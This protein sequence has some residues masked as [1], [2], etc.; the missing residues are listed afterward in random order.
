MRRVFAATL[1][2]LVVPATAG[3][4]VYRWTDAEGRVHY[5]DRAPD[6]AAQRVDLPPSPPAP[7]D[8]EL[9]EQRER[10]RRLLEVWDAE[11]RERAQAAASAAAATAERERACAWLREELDGARRAAYLV[12]RDAQGGRAIVA[13]EERARYQAEL[14]DTIA[15]HCP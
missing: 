14:A 7:A 8:P 10:G 2:S 12:R 11:R 1:L 5:G 3:A 6:G 13:A 15:A 4:E 9:A